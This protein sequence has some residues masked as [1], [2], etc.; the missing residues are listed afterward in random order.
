M[1]AVPRTVLTGTG[2]RGWSISRQANNRNVIEPFTINWT[3]I[4]GYNGGSVRQSY[5][6]VML[7][8]LFL[9]EDSPSTALQVLVW[10]QAEH[11][12]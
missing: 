10:S 7:T 9:S 11:H 6:S 5:V 2:L 4:D 3:T 8:Q 12:L 1:N